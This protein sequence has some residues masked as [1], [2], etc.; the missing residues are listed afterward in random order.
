MENFVIETITN[1]VVP[2]SRIFHSLGVR[3][4]PLIATCLDTSTLLSPIITIAVDRK[5]TEMDL[6][7]KHRLKRLYAPS[8]EGG[9]DDNKC[10]YEL[11]HGYVRVLSP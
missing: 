2:V 4:L 10:F 8:S 5:C 11:D 6:S 9:D 7:L 1:L 3:V